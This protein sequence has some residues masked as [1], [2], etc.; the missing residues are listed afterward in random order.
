MI[1][2]EFLGTTVL[3]RICRLRKMGDLLWKAREGVPQGLK[4]SYPAA[5]Y[6]TAKPVPFV[7]CVF[8]Q[9]LKPGPTQTGPSCPSGREALVAG[10]LGFQLVVLDHPDLQLNLDDF[11][12]TDVARG[13]V[14]SRAIHRRQRPGR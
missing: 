2:N 11:Q 6:G 5:Q 14:E 10:E 4:P 12:R 3:Q 9:P 8:P 1:R 7:K 13:G